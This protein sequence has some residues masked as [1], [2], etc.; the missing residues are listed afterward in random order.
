MPIGVLTW[1]HTHSPTDVTALA[2]Y[3]RD[4][5]AATL[6]EGSNVTLTVNDG[7]D[8]I[9]IAATGGGG[10]GVTAHGDL[11]GLADDDH[12]QYHTDARGDA[13]YYTQAQ[14]NALIAALWPV[15][16][17][18]VSTSATNPASTLGFGTWTAF[19]AGRVLVGLDAGDADFDTVEET[20]GSKTV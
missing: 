11:T 8:T 15:G 1:P 2:E 10:G 4:V 17:V 9:T 16:S 7:A 20:G 18:Y 6:V 12:N 19:G 5:V 13:R 14:V 3:V